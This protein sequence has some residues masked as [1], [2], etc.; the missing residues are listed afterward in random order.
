MN[1][2]KQCGGSAPTESGWRERRP[3]LL[4]LATV[5]AERERFFPFTGTRR[6]L[7]AAADAAYSVVARNRMLFSRLTRW[8]WGA[9]AAAADHTRF[10]DGFFFA[11]LGLSISWRLLPTGCSSAA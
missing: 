1:L 9:D 7:R 10:P 11:C 5:S 4:P 6:R 2:P 8:L 3:F